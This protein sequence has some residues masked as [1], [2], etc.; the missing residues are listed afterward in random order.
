MKDYSSVQAKSYVARQEGALKKY[1]FWQE[2]RLIFQY[3]PIRGRTVLDLGCGTG[4]LTASLIDQGA[5][6]ILACDINTDMVEIAKQRHQGGNITFFEA[7]ATSLPQDDATVDVLLNIGVFEFIKDLTPFLTEMYR[8]LRPNGDLVFTCW[9]SKRW[10]RSNFLD[11]RKYGSVDHSVDEISE[12]LQENGFSVS[13]VET[14][15][16]LPRRLFWIGYKLCFTQF[17]KMGF[18]AICNILSD[19]LR[20]IPILRKKGWVVVMFARKA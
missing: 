19:C 18:V 16:F 8:V 6:E 7:D 17:M 9:N 3:T 12:L 15:F 11:G 2:E 10:Y 5:A 4:R 20:R 14:I 13:R 1:F